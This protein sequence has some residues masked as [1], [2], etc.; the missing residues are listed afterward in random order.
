MIIALVV[1]SL[2]LLGLPC[3]LRR[4]TLARRLPPAEW[5]QLSL[6]LLVFGAVAFET[7]L[8]LLGA[9]TV[10]RALGVPALADICQRMLGDLVPGGPVVGWWAAGSAVAI[11]LIGGR[12]ALRAARAHRALHVESLIGRHEQFGEHELVV[13]PTNQLFA[14][15]LTGDGRAARSQVVVSERLVQELPPTE[16]DAVLR[17]EAAHIEG[18][19]QRY[20]VLITTLEHG[21]VLLPFLRRS[22][23]ALRGALERSADERAAGASPEGRAAL[24]AA[25][26]HVTSAMVAPG[27]TVTAFSSSA[28]SVLERLQAMEEAPPAPGP[29]RA[30]LRRGL[31]YLPAFLLGAA[32]IVSLGL[33]LDQ[34]HFVLATMGICPV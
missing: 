21:L 2:S 14:F 13:L 3:L 32:T 30:S 9:P 23:A 4:L 8:V 15:S 17:H 18:R 22:T 19:H 33:W 28:D 12:G 16:L 29:C 31:V 20:L 34:A 1:S 24:R 25:L 7:A 10:L 6:A 5:A 26:L 27:A 11:P